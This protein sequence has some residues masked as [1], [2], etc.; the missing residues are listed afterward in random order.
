MIDIIYA[1]GGSCF[2]EHYIHR[3]AQRYVL[4]TRGLI[5][6]LESG[7]RCVQLIVCLEIV[8]PYAAG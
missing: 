3:L 1:I 5:L 8:K 6:I 2:G 4:Q 7:T